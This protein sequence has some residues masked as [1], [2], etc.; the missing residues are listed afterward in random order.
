MYLILENKVSLSRSSKCPWKD[1]SNS[2]TFQGVEG[3][4][5]ALSNASHYQLW[6]VVETKAAQFKK[7]AAWSSTLYGTMRNLNSLQK[8]LKFN[9][10]T[11]YIHHSIQHQCTI[12]QWFG[13][14]SYCI[15]RLPFCSWCCKLTQ[16][17]L[18][19]TENHLELES[20]V[21]AHFNLS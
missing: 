1:S 17:R 2:R 18:K 4:A 13:Q 11:T 16:D 21:I 15:C 3:P 7:L 12:P 5:W 19:T 20:K 8:V 10:K 14:A 9:S 6:M